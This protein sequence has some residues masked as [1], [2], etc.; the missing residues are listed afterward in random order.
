MTEV[1]DSSGTLTAR[2]D[3]RIGAI[4]RTQS[5]K[6]FAMER[7]LADQRNV[8]VIDSK[9]RVRWDGYYMT[10]NLRSALVEPKTIFRHGSGAIPDAFWMRAVEWIHERGGGVIYIDEIPV[11]TGPNRIQPGLAEAFRMGA[12]IGVGVWWSAQESTGIH[13]TVMRQ[14]EVV[15]LFLNVGA[16]D[17]D[18]VIKTYGDIG[19]VT[20]YLKP[21]QFVVVENFGEPYDPQA[22]P[23]WSMVE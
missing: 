12:E 16:S 10:Y 19:E 14:S 9:H 3:Q 5:G 13:N 23:V 21:R 11:L 22:I 6:T 2:S 8:L 17:R 1:T 7:L 4:G 20:A 15:L 18:K